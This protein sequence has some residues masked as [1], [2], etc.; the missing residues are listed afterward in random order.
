MANNNQQLIDILSQLPEYIAYRKNEKATD[1]FEY[2]MELA[3]AIPT[4]P[5]YDANLVATTMNTML[6]EPYKPYK[7]S[8]TVHTPNL[9]NP[10]IS[11]PWNPVVTPTPTRPVVPPTPVRPVISPTNT[12][13]KPPISPQPLYGK[14]YF[15]PA[16]N[17]PIPSPRIGISPINYPQSPNM[18]KLPPLTPTE[19]ATWY[20][21]YPT[22]KQRK[23]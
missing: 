20:S 4:I 22:K 10:P 8:I 16:P 1:S 19:Y 21:T 14:P 2:L 7:P 17:K 13:Y 5:G 6:H 23:L 15:A 11:R 9:F 18:T 3:M 12:P